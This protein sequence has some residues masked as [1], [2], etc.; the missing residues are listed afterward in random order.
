[1]ADGAW[2]FERPH[3]L[4]YATCVEYTHEILGV[5]LCGG[6]EMCASGGSTI[7][8]EPV[9]LDLSFG[10][11]HAAT[12]FGLKP[13]SRPMRDTLTGRKSLLHNEAHIF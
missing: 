7:R 8:P 5:Q 1:M 6:T 11:I 2:E 3:C 10:R 12:S 13:A 4:A 9:S